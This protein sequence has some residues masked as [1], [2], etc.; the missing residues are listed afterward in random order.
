VKLSLLSRALAT[1]VLTILLLSGCSHFRVHRDYQKATEA[2][3]LE[4]P[5]E[6]DKP[7]N[8]GELIIPAVGSKTG[9][10]SS[11][12]S[13]APPQSLPV[14]DSKTNSAIVADDQLVIPDTVENTWQRVGLALERSRTG[15]IVQRDE[16][17]HSYVV[18]LKSKKK[19]KSKGSIF[20]RW[21]RSDSTLSSHI[22]LVIKIIPEDERAKIHIDGDTSHPETIEMAR[23][24][25]AV[26]KE[27]LS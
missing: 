8:P 27:R 19:Q 14:G 6:L 2:K 17:G 21:F 13:D 18:M 24:V 7:N 10:A 26:L 4:I 15:T 20:T 11:A 16:S 5:P 25:M 23:H 1:V 12:T 9:L 3:P 22:Q